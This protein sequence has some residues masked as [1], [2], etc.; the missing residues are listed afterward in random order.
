M[1]VVVDNSVS[2][3]FVREK[4]GRSS[5][6]RPKGL[7]L[8]LLV[9]LLM[10]GF[11]AMP[12]WSETS[13]TMEKIKAFAAVYP[14]LFQTGSGMQ[15]VSNRAGQKPNMHVIKLLMNSYHNH[16]NYE[17]LSA[18]LQPGEGSPI[19]TENQIKALLEHREISWPEFVAMSQGIARDPDMFETFVRE[20]D[21]ARVENDLVA[22]ASQDP[23][24]ITQ[25]PFAEQRQ[26]LEQL[27]RRFRK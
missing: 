4:E 9:P 11:A 3:P 1:G 24:F 22:R 6:R 15:P 7:V 14:E 18:A 27:V 13:M 8:T 25:V 17:E 5:M 2:T 21:Q 23:D 16:T 26:I 19:K 10:S 20:L 12:A